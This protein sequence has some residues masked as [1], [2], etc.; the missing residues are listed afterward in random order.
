MKTHP[1][2]LPV[3]VNNFICFREMIDDVRLSA[4]VDS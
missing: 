4:I 1:Q 3:A 2:N